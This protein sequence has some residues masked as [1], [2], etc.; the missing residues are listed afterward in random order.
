QPEKPVSTVKI[1][2]VQLA[3]FLDKYWRTESLTSLGSS[4]SFEFGLQLIISGIEK[5]LKI[6]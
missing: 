6:N 4:E 3:P 1:P 2:L 5:M